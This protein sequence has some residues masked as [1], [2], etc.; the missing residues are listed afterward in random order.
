MQHNWCPFCSSQQGSPEPF[1]GLINSPSLRSEV[2][3]QGKHWAILHD[4]APIAPYHVLA[5]SRRHFPSSV[6][7]DAAE[8]EEL[9]ELKVK[10]RDFHKK[11]TGLP[12]LFFEHGAANEGYGSACIVHAHLHAVPV[13]WESFAPHILYQ[14]NDLGS[15][16]DGPAQPGTAYLMI[17]F[18][19]GAQVTWPDSGVP[20]QFFRQLTARAVGYP[21]RGRWQSC[22]MPEEIER[23]KT[24]MLECAGK[25]AQV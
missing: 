17:E 16:L 9:S 2:I 18:G 12:T 25:W 20:C 8:A 14:L 13:M 23:T 1:R 24:W 22:L 7:S 4:I 15:P 5:V 21:E 19:A 11:Q 3:F 10:I 6:C